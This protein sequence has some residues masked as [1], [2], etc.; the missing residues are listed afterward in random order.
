MVLIFL[1]FFSNQYYVLLYY[2]QNH[3]KHF[4]IVKFLPPLLVMVHQQL[5]SCPRVWVWV[6]DDNQLWPTYHHVLVIKSSDHHCDHNISSSPAA[7]RTTSVKTSSE[8]L[9]PTI[10]ELSTSG[11]PVFFILQKLLK[12]MTIIFFLLQKLLKIKTIIARA[13]RQSDF[14]L[15]LVFKSRCLLCF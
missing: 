5:N 11:E 12:I 14:F 15:T 3:L 7:M 2:D 4:P 13:E 9:T 8:H 1:F 6:P 10:A